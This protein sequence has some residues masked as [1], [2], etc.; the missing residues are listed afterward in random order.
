[1]DPRH[2]RRPEEA[3]RRVGKGSGI[4]TGRESVAPT[5]GPDWERQPVRPAVG[6]KVAVHGL[7]KVRLYRVV[8]DMMVRG[9]FVVIFA[10]RTGELAVYKRS[11][12][13][14]RSHSLAMLAAFL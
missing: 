1:M 2:L 11:T 4:D 6:V 12:F 7:C 5:A 13:F 14:V 10:F 3:C 9:E 8:A